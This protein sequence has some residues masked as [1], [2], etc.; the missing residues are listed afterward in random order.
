[1]TEVTETEAPVLLERGRHAIVAYPETVNLEKIGVV[2]KG[3]WVIYRAGPLCESC[4]AC[5]CGEQAEPWVLPPVV[6][7]ILTM[8]PDERAKLNPMAIMKRLMRGG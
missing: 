4:E 5:G 7:N 8:D 6:A 1:M 3:S 2:A